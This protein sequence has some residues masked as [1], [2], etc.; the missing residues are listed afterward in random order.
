MKNEDISYE[1]M[2]VY[3]FKILIDIYGVDKA[4]IL[5][6]KLNSVRGVKI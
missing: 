2:L 4:I 1:E 6:Y 3:V 5:L